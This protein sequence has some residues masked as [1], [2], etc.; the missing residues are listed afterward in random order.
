MSANLNRRAV[1]AGA[2]AAAPA[3]ADPNPDAE[4]IA[5]GAQLEPIIQAWHA[6]RAKDAKERAEFEPPGCAGRGP[7]SPLGKAAGLRMGEVSR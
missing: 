3:I 4:L 7:R 1:L 6:K 2:T 5:L